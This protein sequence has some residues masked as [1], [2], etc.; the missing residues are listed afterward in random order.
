MDI[1][2]LGA[3]KTVTGSCFM[4]TTNKYKFLVDCGMFQ[5]QNKE[6][7]LNVD[8]FTFAPKDID[9]VLLTHAHIDH[10]GR[11]P[12]L[13]NDGFKGK[14]YAT[15]ATTDL[16]KVMLPDSGHIQE[17]EIEWINKKR[18]RAGKHVIPPLYTVDDAVRS[19]EHFEPVHYNELVTINENVKVMFRDAGHMLGSSI[20]EVWVKENGKETK[21]VFTG[22]L[23]N[24]DTPILRDPEFIDSADVLVMESTYGDRN[25]KEREDR[26]E[27]FLDIVNDTID[28]GG[29]VVI[30][31]FAVGRT[32]EIVYGLNAN[33][34]K[35]GEKYKKILKIP[36][37]M[38][39]PLAISATEIYKNNAECYDEEARRYIV[40]GDNPVD[41]PTLI[42]TKSVDESKAINESQEPAI[43]ISASGMC[44][45][46][47]I[48]HHLKHSLWSE[49][50][51][52]LFVGY[53]AVGTLGRRLIDGEKQVRLFGE[54][55]S[56][57]ARIEYIEG[58]SGHADQT[59]LLNWFDN[60]KH[61]P[62]NVFIV[63]GEEESQEV[64]AEKIKER[65]VNVVIPNRGDVFEITT[66][67]A[68]QIGEEA[69]ERRYRFMCLEVL[70]KLELL[71]DEVDEMCLILKEDLRNG[72]DESE[73]GEMKGKLRNIEKSIIS[74]LE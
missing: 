37:Y 41:F 28:N 49:K 5:G 45:A 55:I 43:V 23:G 33:Q 68:N 24:N 8:D 57:N 19:L 36:V 52:V 35:Y 10:S 26:F 17:N 47:R 72:M 38:D 44:E 46:G 65:G 42:L 30:P 58:F 51:T 74:A 25:H 14:V 4:V 69:K 56:V 62:S 20:I 13:C 64:F 34:E 2:F 27:Q 50:N 66:E 61:K 32:Q 21:I 12:K 59:A 40:E 9:F 29:R 3:A 31:S 71:K 48:R 11:I 22:D 39:S 15:K 63:H 54:D 53:Q 70:E 1:S 6:T 60:I 67:R 18:I 73:F 16:C 7:M